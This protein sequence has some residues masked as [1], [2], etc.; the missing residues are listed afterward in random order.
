M[1]SQ[2]SR[3]LKWLLPAVLA[4]S[5]I[6]YSFYRRSEV[7]YWDGAVGNWLATLF[8]ILVGIPVALSLER[9]RINLEKAEQQRADQ[10]TKRDVLI[11]LQTE[12]VDAQKKIAQRISLGS[13]IPVEPLKTS[14]WEAMKATANLRHVAELP[15][16]S[17]LSEAYRLIQVLAETEKMLH[18]TIYGVNVQFTDGENAA[19][20]ILRNAVAFHAPTLTTIDHALNAVAAALDSLQPS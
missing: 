2:V 17:S 14:A 6:G 20:K 11:L 4:A 16:I 9:N 10:R 13:S 7:A 19:T 18:R 12:L 8:G 1:A 5:A 3:T 15:L